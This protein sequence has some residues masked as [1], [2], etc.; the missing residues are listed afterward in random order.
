MSSGRYSRLAGAI[1]ALCVALMSVLAPSARAAAGVPDA[2]GITILIRTTVLALNDANRT[3]NYT[4]FRDLASP[5]FRANNTA[6][7]L[8]EI[9]ARLRG[10]NLDLA[11]VVLFDPKLAEPPAIDESGR[12]R[13]MGHFPTRPLQVNFDLAYDLVDGRWR[14]FGIA[15]GTREAEAKTPPQGKQGKQDKAR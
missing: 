8:G 6:A 15:I 2:A 14:L 3:G 1:L 10:Q 5:T 11:P 9:F 4:V 12:L 7:R 13:L